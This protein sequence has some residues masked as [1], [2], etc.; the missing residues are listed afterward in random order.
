MKV[1]PNKATKAP[2]AAGEMQISPEDA[3]VKASDP[4]FL[5]AFESKSFF[6]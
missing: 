3:F 5:A 6:I 2:A 4:K 1:V